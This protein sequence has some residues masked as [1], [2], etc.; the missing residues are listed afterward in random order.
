MNALTLSPTFPLRTFSP[1]V[2]RRVDFVARQRFTQ[3]RHQ[4]PVAR[5]K[6]RMRRLVL[7]RGASRGSARP[8]LSCTGHAGTKQIR[9]RPFARAS[10]T[11]SS[12]RREVTAQILR[13]GIEA[14][15]RFDRMLRVQ[16]TRSFDDRRRRDDKRH[17]T[18]LGVSESALTVPAS[19][20]SI[21]P[22][23]TFDRRDRAIEL[24]SVAHADRLAGTRPLRSR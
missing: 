22:A 20:R 10:S 13:A 5:K 4:R 7:F 14:C 2:F 15:D 11:S 24:V 16:R 12:M 19:A 17:A 9:L 23:K 6:D 1:C 18:M 8:G 3:H 21:A